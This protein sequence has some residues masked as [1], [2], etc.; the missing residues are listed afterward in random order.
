L[1][2]LGTALLYLLLGLAPAAALAQEA[3][4]LALNWVPRADHMPFVFAQ[5]QG[6]YRDAG[7]DLTIESLTGSPA[8]VKRAAEA[9]HTFAVADFVPFLREWTRGSPVTAV[10][11]LEPRSPFA[12]YVTAE[13]GIRGLSDVV[14]RRIAAQ[15]AD[16]L[17]G[18]WPAFAADL[19]LDPQRVTWIE[20]ANPAKPDALNGG[21]ADAA[22]NP[23][24]HNHLNYEAV[25][26]EHMRVLWWHDA[27]FP[28]YGHVLVASA[29]TLQTTPQL[30]QRFVDV[31]RR[32]WLHCLRTPEPCLEALLEEYP[33]LDRAN[34]QALWKLVA[35]LH[36]NTDPGVTLGAFD[37]E[38]VRRSIAQ[39]RAAYGLP[40]DSAGDA[41]STNAFVMSP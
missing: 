18:L 31:T 12:T 21:E 4:T 32:A 26:G 33:Q 9:S 27:G 23:F 36:G 13:S 34:E 16:L 14:G 40:A 8:A 1:R 38:R 39:V 3:V 29:N 25:L 20:L 15:P 22:F 10:M 11:V 35:G 24:L 2:T 30:V 6:W 5:K 17:R 28:A 19:G 37:P 7:I 41:A